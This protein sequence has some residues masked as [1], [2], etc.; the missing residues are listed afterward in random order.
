[1]E[2]LGATRPSVGRPVRRVALQRSLGRGREQD[3]SSLEIL[4]PD[5]QSSHR[6][7]AAKGVSSAQRMAQTSSQSAK[8]AAAVGNLCCNHRLSGVDRGATDG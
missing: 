4:S 2:R 1:M 5:L 8:V 3:I 6:D 7:A